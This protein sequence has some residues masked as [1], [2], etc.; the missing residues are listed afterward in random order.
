MGTVSQP[1]SFGYRQLFMY[2][3]RKGSCHQPDQGSVQARLCLVLHPPM[4]HTS[5]VLEPQGPMPVEIQPLWVSSVV[6]FNRGHH[7]AAS[8]QICVGKDDRSI[9]CQAS[10]L[11]EVTTRGPLWVTAARV[12]REQV[13]KCGQVSRGSGIGI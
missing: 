13:V 11:G 10:E 4:A 2:S 9:V 3:K 6:I 12:A 5:T 8:V 1:T 7:D